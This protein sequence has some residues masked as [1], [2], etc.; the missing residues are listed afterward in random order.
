MM[1]GSYRPTGELWERDRTGVFQSLPVNL[2]KHLGL[3]C[4]WGGGP[5][6]PRSLTFSLLDK[7]SIS[8]SGSLLPVALYML[9]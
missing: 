6:L 4:R 3:C 5:L 7:Q 9:I 8:F 2:C 1:A